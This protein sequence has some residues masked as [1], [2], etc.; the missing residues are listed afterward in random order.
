MDMLGRVGPL[1]VI[2]V[3]VMH[4]QVHQR[5]GGKQEKGQELDHVRPVLGEQK[6]GNHE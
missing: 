3:A 2:T 6:I 1:I 4:E 5:A